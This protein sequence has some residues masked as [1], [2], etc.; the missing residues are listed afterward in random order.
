MQAT[1]AATTTT[2]IATT[3]GSA[4][5]EHYKPAAERL[6]NAIKRDL[7]QM[8][9]GTYK[10]AM[11]RAL[12]ELSAREAEYLSLKTGVVAD[13]A[14]TKGVIMTLAS[15]MVTDPLVWGKDVKG[16]KRAFKDMLALYLQAQGSSI[17]PLPL[18]KGVTLASA[19]KALKKV[20]A[21]PK[22]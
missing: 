7:Q 22:F 12:A 20:P 19:I 6:E 14:V 2:T 13:T 5:A 10:Y 17:Q 4:I 3:T 9:Q 8:L 15:A 16:Q 18:Q 1:I 11:G 21:L